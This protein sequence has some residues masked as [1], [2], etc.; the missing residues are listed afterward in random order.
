MHQECFH[1]VICGWWAADVMGSGK[2]QFPGSLAM[3]KYPPTASK[4]TGVAI[5]IP[6]CS[7]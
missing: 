7:A 6:L 4:S 3:Q 2:D 5:H 1:K